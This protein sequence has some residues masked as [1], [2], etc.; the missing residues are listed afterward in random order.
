[1]KY[2]ILFSRKNKKKYHLGNL[3]IVYEELKC[4]PFTI[5]ILTSKIR[6]PYPPFDY[7]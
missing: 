3:P 5:F 2:Q 1:M 6:A 4:L 7:I